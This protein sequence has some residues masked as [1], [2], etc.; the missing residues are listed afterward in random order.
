VEDAASQADY[1]VIEEALLEGGL[2]DDA[3]AAK[4]SSELNRRRWIRTLPPENMAPKEVDPDENKLALT[5][6]GHVFTLRNKHTT[7]AYA[8]VISNQVRELLLDAEFITAGIVD[9]NTVEFEIDD[10]GRQ[11]VWEVLRDAIE[12]GN[13]SGE[14]YTGG[15][16]RDLYFD[17]QLASKAVEYS[18]RGGV[19]AYA[20]G[21]IVE[22]WLAA[23]GLLRLED[24]PGGQATLTDDQADDARVCFMEE[25]EFDAKD[26]L[27]GGYGLSFS[28]ESVR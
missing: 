21:G 24:M 1:G 25:V 15:V 5:F 17:Y 12:A 13:V 16:F 20:N 11:R 26:W 6:Y 8:D 23:P 10:R 18:Y 3:A 2:S 22:P 4:V 14:R 7:R 19:I 27:D 9:A 28:R